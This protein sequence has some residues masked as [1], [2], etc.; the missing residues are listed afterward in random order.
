[1]STILLIAPATTANAVADELRLAL[2]TTVEIAST[3]RAALGILRR[4]EFG[5]VLIE[6]A[7]GSDP[8]ITDL[9]YQ[10]VGGAMIVELNFAISSAPR[11]VR[12]ARAALS[13]RAHDQT[14]ARAA[15]A[16]SLHSELNATLAGLLL[17]SQLALREATPAQAPKL[18][19][20]VQLAG[21]LRE[22]LR[23]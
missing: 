18:R 22:R 1:M 15:A 3:H 12:Q 5:L 23:V 20:L 10:S 17:E 14:L 13:R 16:A 6:E 19:H 11:I 7:L 4:R 9:L 21:D 2:D 8:E